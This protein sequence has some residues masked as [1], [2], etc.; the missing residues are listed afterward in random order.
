MFTVRDFLLS[1]DV[2]GAPRE[3]VIDMYV[4]NKGTPSAQSKAG[5]LSICMLY[6]ATLVLPLECKGA[7]KFLDEFVNFPPEFRDICST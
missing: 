7:C 6:T 2:R 1:K 3:S 4:D 5:Y